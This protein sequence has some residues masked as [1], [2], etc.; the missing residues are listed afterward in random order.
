MHYIDGYVYA[1]PTANKEAFRKYA[2]ESAALFKK[3]GALQVIEGWGEDVPT[4]KVT[5]LYSA[6]QAKEDETIMF[7]WVIWADKAAREAGNAK[8]YED[9]VA[10]GTDKTEMPFDGKRMIYGGFE[11]LVEM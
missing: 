1:V 6:V 5:D 11:A 9:M 8:V 10:A 3:H 2:E 4:G 7:S